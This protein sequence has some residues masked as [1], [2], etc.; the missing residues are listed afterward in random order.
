MSRHV[1]LRTLLVASAAITGLLVAVQPPAQAATPLDDPF[2]KY[3]G[4]TPLDKITK[5]TVLKTRTVPYTLTGLFVPVKA[6]Q[7]L[8]RTRDMA[9]RATVNVT[10][11]IRPTL[12]TVARMVSYQ[13]SYDSLNPLDEP[14]AS[15]VQG[16]SVAGSVPS[17]ETKLFVP[18]LT[19]GYTIN[20]P[21]HEGQTAELGAGPAYGYTTLDSIRAASSTASG[22][23][24]S[25]SS[26]VALMGYGGGGTASE[27]ASELAGL[28]APAVASRLVGTAIGGAMVDPGHALRYVEGSA[29]WASVE[30]ML[31]TGIA[32]AF[33]VDLSPYLSANGTNVMTALASASLTTA[34]G[35]NPG[36]TWSQIAKSAYTSPEMIKPYVKAVNQ[37]TMGF[38]GKPLA[39]MYIGHGTGGN[40]DGTP[41]Y[42]TYGNGDGISPAGDARTLART[43]CDKGASIKYEEYT[44]PHLSAA[45]SWLQVAYPWVVD[46]FDGVKA[47][48]SCGSIAAGNSLAPLAWVL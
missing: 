28:Y 41:Q 11:V 34:K 45:G 10:T 13:P 18:L 19:A 33:S 25:A 22:T 14:S 12:T 44:T 40:V 1:R 47:P 23:G 48:T 42:G 6:T 8:Y 26:K 31:L 46:R 29:T 3:T 4:T 15:I 7:V 35:T 5:G 9:G 16:K 27:W 37:L 36:L 2:Y 17:L 21:D 30:P 24:V 39:P 20:V 43:Y 32:R 38:N